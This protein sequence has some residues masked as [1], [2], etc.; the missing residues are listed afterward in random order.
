MYENWQK[1]KIRSIGCIVEQPIALIYS[2][3][4]LFIYTRG[5]VMIQ[6]RHMTYPSRR[7]LILYQLESEVSTKLG[8]RIPLKVRVWVLLKLL[9]LFLIYFPCY[10]R[11]EEVEPKANMLLVLLGIHKK[12]FVGS[13]SRPLGPVCAAFSRS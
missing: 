5:K 6:V 12:G 13:V 10:V 7:L 8:V 3:E 9:F 1:K 4:F 11:K 2:H